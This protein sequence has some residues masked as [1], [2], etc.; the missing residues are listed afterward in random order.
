MATS[1]CEVRVREVVRGMTLEVSV[2]GLRLQRWR[3]HIA[4]P[5][6]HLGAWVAGFGAVKY[7]EE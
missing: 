1:Q 6:F 4:R 7:K 5:L 2:K 3:F